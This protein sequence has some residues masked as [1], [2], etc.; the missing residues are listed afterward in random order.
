MIGEVMINNKLKK[1]ICDLLEDD[2][3]KMN[4]DKN[5]NLVTDLNFDSL[6]LITLIIEVESQFN[7]MIDDDDLDIDKISSVE[8]IDKLVENVVE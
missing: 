7:V 3:E 1:I 6:K 5:T 2:Y 4:I 8:Y